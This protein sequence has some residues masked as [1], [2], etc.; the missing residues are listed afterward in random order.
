LVVPVVSVATPTVGSPVTVVTVVEV[1]RAWTDRT[2]PQVFPLSTVV[3]AVAEVTEASVVR[4]QTATVE[5]VA[6]RAVAVTEATVAPVLPWATSPTERPEAMEASV[7]REVVVEV[8]RRG[9]RVTAAT[10]VM[11][12]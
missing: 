7:E 1:E 10:V 12:D 5:T 8:H 3:T 9:S 2:Q 4:R 6:T 11:A